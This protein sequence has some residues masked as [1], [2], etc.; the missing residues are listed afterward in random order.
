TWSTRRPRAS[1]AT[2]SPRASTRPRVPSTVS[3]ARTTTSSDRLRSGSPGHPRTMSEPGPAPEPQID[4]DPDPGNEAGGTDAVE[5][6]TQ[7]PPLSRE[8]PLS[9]QMDDEDLP[10]A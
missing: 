5:E 4:P 10:D 8:S 6:E 9:A 1:T 2:R 3:T 7:L